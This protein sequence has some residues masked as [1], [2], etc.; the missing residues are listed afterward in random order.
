MATMAPRDWQS[1]AKSSFAYLM[2]D[3]GFEP[4]VTG[5]TGLRFKLGQ[6]AVDVY[7]ND[8]WHDEADVGIRLLG[9]DSPEPLRT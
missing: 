3:L 6:L 7:Y 9:D 8:E 1:L 2:D 4:E 5:P